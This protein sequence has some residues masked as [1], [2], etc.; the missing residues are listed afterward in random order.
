M[1]RNQYHFDEIAFKLNFCLHPQFEKYSLYKSLCVCVW[2]W[3]GLFSLLTYYQQLMMIRT[4]EF[5]YCWFSFSILFLVTPT[6][7]GWIDD[8]T[9]GYKKKDFLNELSSIYAGFQFI[10]YDLNRL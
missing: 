9:F 4:K 5:N 6:A 8:G 10:Q 7:I 3:F 2:L 1:N